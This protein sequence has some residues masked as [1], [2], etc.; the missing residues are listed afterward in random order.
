MN[1]NRTEC[2]TRPLLSATALG[3]GLGYL[4]LGSA[5]SRA[6]ARALLTAQ[7]EGEGTLLRLRFVGHSPQPDQKCTCPK[8]PAGTVALCRCF[9]PLDPP[10]SEGRGL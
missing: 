8:P 2:D 9:G 3:R 7:Q 6:A 5:Q 1:K 10:L 4:P